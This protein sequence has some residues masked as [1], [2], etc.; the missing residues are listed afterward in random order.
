MAHEQTRPGNLMPDITLPS[1]RVVSLD[2]NALTISEYRD[3]FKPESSIDDDEILSKVAGIERSELE[4]FGMLDYRA[5]VK[6]FFRHAG[7]PL[8]DPS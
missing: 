6:E 3:L 4:G 5:L 2:Y 7:D 1:G 8:A